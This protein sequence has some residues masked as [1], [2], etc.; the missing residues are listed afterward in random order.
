MHDGAAL[1]VVENLL[2]AQA[3]QSVSAVREQAP[4]RPWPGWHTV[5]GVQAEALAADQ[6]VP[7]AHSEHFVFDV[8]EQAADS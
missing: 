1:V 2:A 4:V 6:D 8:G 5:Q 3:A 7:I